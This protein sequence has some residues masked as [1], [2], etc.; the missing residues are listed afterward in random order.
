[1]ATHASA[2]AVD[3]V[4]LRKLRGVDGKAH[5]L[6][7]L[8]G[9]RATVLLFIATN[10]PTARAYG[11]RLRVLDERYRGRGVQFVAVNS[12]NP[13]LSP[14]DTYDAMLQ[15]APLL[16]FDFP[17]VKDQD[18]TVARYVGA[19][20]TPHAFL[21]DANS[22]VVYDGR[23]DDSRLGNNIRTS[24][25]DDAIAAVLREEPVAVAH[26]EPFGCAIVW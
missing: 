12:N 25:L 9:E 20:C 7:A 23:I 4:R 14:S 17:Y 6:A 3:D 26:T 15:R 8:A 13:Y 18:G 11:E 16:G 19:V 5:S 2:D 1:M 21:L 22:R 10:C 24:D